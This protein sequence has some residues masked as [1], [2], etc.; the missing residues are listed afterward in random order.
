[1][2]IKNVTANENGSAYGLTNTA[3][4][5]YNASID[6]PKIAKNYDISISATDE[7]GNVTTI[8]STDERFG[9]SLQL[10][11]KHSTKTADLRQVLLTNELGDQMLDTVSPIYD[12]SAMTL[13]AFEA[14]GETISQDKDFI[15]G[16]F[17]AQMFPQTATW[18]LRLWEDEYGIATDVSKKL[19]QRRQYLMGAMYKHSPMTPKRIEEV[20][21]AV[22]GTECE[23]EENTAPNTVTISVFGYVSN[24]QQLKNELDAKL[25]AHIHYL[26]NTADQENISTTTYSGFG[27]QEVEKVKVEV[28]N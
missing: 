6:A 19:D 14:F 5:D 4:E 17:I 27:V 20:V 26:I 28:M 1:M 8:D 2:A 15:D 24:L 11:V 9:K 12:K 10:Q 23:V 22:T 21:Y 18:G 25:P 16:D 13:Y 7:A 3:G